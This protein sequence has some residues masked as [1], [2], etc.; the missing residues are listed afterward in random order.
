MAKKTSSTNSIKNALV[1]AAA[2][3]QPVAKVSWKSGGV[4][5]SA[6]VTFDPDSLNTHLVPIGQTA[7][8]LIGEVN[9]SGQL[10]INTLADIPN[11]AWNKAS[12]LYQAL[13]GELPREVLE[14]IG[15]ADKIDLREQAKA[16]KLAK[17]KAKIEA[18]KLEA[19][20]QSESELTMIAQ[21][22]KASSNGKVAVTA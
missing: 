9:A 11:Q 21:P 20:I 15:M 7:G 13:Y 12:K 17:R 19:T 18:K 22:S 1:K 5:Y 10:R 4:P 6:Y 8:E 3:V 16:E 14:A 2:F